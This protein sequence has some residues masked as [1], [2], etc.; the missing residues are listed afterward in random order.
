MGLSAHPLLRH[1]SVRSCGLSGLPRVVHDAGMN[2]S[3][4]PYHR[5]DSGAVADE[6][7]ADEAETRGHLLTRSRR[8]QVPIYK[9]FVQH[10]D[11]RLATRA[12]PLSEFVRNGDL[13][14]LRAI[15]FLHAIIS[16]G[17]KGWSATLPLAVWARVFDT[18]KNAEPRSASTAATKVLTRLAERNLITR[19]RSGRARS[20]TV[21]LLRPDGSGEP[22]TRPGASNTDRFLNLS[23]QFWTDG[24]YEQLDLPATAML[25]VAA[26]E[27]SGF[28]LVTERVPKWYG[29]SADTAERGLQT[30]HDRGLLDVDHRIK[31]A[32]LSPTGATRVN[33]YTLIGPFAPPQA[34]KEPGRAVPTRA[35]K[36]RKAKATKPT[37]KQATA[38]ETAGSGR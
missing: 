26:H 18:T 8:T 5:G 16:S 2:Q 35:T 14:G 38:S 23:H 31:K 20:I 4:T 25:L 36:T 13:R 3:T 17:D 32:P 6:A 9:G 21:T 24:W 30:L 37:K 12:G 28:E 19:A 15:L 1:F 10:P 33:V 29:W 22:Y 34:K 7:P 27:K 11:K